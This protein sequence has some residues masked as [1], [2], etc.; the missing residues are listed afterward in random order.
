MGTDFNIVGTI[1][2]ERGRGSQ[3]RGA[4]QL[5]RKIFY[6]KKLNTM[7]DFK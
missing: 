1:N 3:F 7:E 6:G 2:L 5:A 4:N